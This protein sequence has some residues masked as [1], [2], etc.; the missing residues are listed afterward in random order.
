MTSS[1]HGDTSTQDVATTT[2][3]SMMYG[4]DRLGLQDSQDLLVNGAGVD[5]RV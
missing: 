2:I 1:L 4:Q 3:I 5:Q